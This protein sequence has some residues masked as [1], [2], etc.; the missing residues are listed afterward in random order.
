MALQHLDTSD[1]LDTTELRALAR[2]VKPAL[3]MVVAHWNATQQY[4][5]AHPYRQAVKMVIGYLERQYRV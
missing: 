5:P 2:V 4:P 1:T 3:L